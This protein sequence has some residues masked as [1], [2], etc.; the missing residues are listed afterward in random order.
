MP[1]SLGEALEELK[2][3]ELVRAVFGEHLFESYVEAKKSEWD[4]Y[5]IN[6]SDWELKRYLPIY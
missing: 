5:R 3:S 1:G 6:V 4:E 2:Q